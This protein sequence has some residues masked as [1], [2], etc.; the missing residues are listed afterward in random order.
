EPDPDMEIAPLWEV[1]IWEPDTGLYYY[2]NEDIDETYISD[3]W[4]LKGYTTTEEV[5]T[6]SAD[7][8]TRTVTVTESAKRTE[9]NEVNLKRIMTTTTVT[10][11]T[12]T[13]LATGASTVTT[14]TATTTEIVGPERIGTLIEG[15]DPGEK[16]K[17]GVKI[18]NISAANNEEIVVHFHFAPVDCDGHFYIDEEVSTLDIYCKSSDRN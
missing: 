14:T 9:D 5:T 11:V 12:V 3:W 16:I 6:L 2:S 18:Q 4:N 17:I 7:G 8:L 10:T 1:H 13:T 15:L